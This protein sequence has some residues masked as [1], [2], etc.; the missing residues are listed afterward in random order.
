M[1][2]GYLYRIMVCIGI[3]MGFSACGKYLDEMPQN[4]M[5]PSTTEDYEQLL[6]KAYITKPVLGYLDMMTDDMSLNVS[7]YIKGAANRADE[8]MGAFLWN[9]SIETT[10]LNGDQ[11]FEFFYNSIFYTNVVIDNIDDALGVVLDESAV[12]L[13]RGSI[14]GEALALRAYSYFYLV[15][16]YAGPYD[17]ATC[18]TT[19]G[20]PIN[21]STAAEDKAYTRASLKAVYEQMVEDLKE[22]IRLMEENPVEKGTKLRLNAIAARALLARVYLY[23]HEWDLA[24][25]QASEVIKQNPAIY[26]LHEA[27]DD[28]AIYSDAVIRG[29]NAANVA[30]KDYLSVDN[31]N[32]LFANGVNELYMIFNT[33]PNYS[34]FAVNRDLA[35]LYDKG[36]VRKCYFMKDY[37]RGGSVQR[38]MYAKNRYYMPV[39]GDNGIELSPDYG[40][41]RVIRTEEMYL[42]LAEAY[43]QKDEVGTAIGY[44]NQLREPKFVEGEYAPLKV[45]DYNKNTLLEKVYLERRL[46]LCFEGHRWFDLRRTTRP[47]MKHRGLDGE[48]VLKENDP[49]YVLQIP[50]NELS[51]NPEIGVN[52]R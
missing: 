2:S 29:W 35:A 45:G 22:G 12:R 47:E 15:N 49:R 36:D 3:C 23:M 6:N 50:A 41:V 32:V 19:P 9:N 21:L 31:A 27:G 17:P 30:G 20:V 39:G 1:K 13:S 18:E 25:E 10:M 43:A 16:L 5:K 33:V 52:P 48:V 14:K 8:F 26:N 4:K 44:L 38:L 24:I 7:D 42:A 28:P 51:V 46:E 37:L 34:V 11:A 40:F